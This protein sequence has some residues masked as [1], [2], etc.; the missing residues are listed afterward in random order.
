MTV[1]ST[2]PAVCTAS[3]FVITLLGPG[4][5]ALTA[6]QAG[7]PTYAAASPVSRSFTVSKATQSITFANPGDRPSF[8]TPLTVTATAS[9]NLPV[10]VTTTTTG[11]L[12]GQRLPGHARGDRDVHAHRQPAR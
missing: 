2:T 6:S 4:T 3:G 1:T 5:C 8:Q 12:H 7:S 9:S 10:A 11:R